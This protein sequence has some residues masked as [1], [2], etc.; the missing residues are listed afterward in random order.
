MSSKS[1]SHEWEK[2][3]HWRCNTLLIQSY[4][5]C[6]IK[7]FRKNKYCQRE[8]PYGRPTTG[9]GDPCL[10]TGKQ[11]NIVHVVKRNMAICAATALPHISVN[12][13]NSIV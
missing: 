2:S 9:H 10:L 11:Q 13:T 12:Y 1:R 3:K 7:C 4:V 5:Y 6:I 8:R